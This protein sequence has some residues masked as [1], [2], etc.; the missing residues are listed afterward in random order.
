VQAGLLPRYDRL[1]KSLGLPVVVPLHEHKCG[2]CHLKVSS[3]IE[4]EAR[5]RT[6]IVACDN[7]SRIIYFEL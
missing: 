7:C 2:G 6:E 4:A 1:A 5:K 3:G